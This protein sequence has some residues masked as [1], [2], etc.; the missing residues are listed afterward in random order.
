MKRLCI[1]IF[2]FSFTLILFQIAGSAQTAG[3]PK[4]LPNRTMLSLS[5]YQKNNEVELK[6]V[7]SASHSYDKLIIERAAIL[8]VFEKAGEINIA[9]TA[10]T[11]FHFTYL[12]ANPATG[13]NYYRI[14]LINS[15]TKVHE[16]TNTLMIKMDNDTKSLTIV[17]TVM[18]VG[19]P[20]LT[21]KC[22]ED[23]EASF[24][25]LDLNGRILKTEQFKLNNGVNNITLSGFND[26]RGLFL[27]IVRTKKKTTSQRV[28]VQ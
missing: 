6:G 18:Q 5:G 28:L 14:M 7:L 4:P 17:N 25:T 21:V 20:V 23:E 15:I 3:N 24:Q 2:L 16:F 22:I 19:S 11:E 8:G 1:G 26:S 27:I 10:S 9:G 13:V 12:D